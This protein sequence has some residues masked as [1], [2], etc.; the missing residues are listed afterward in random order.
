[1]S[2]M[3]LRKFIM[4]NIVNHIYP[5]G[6]MEY[7]IKLN[8]NLC[9]EERLTILKNICEKNITLMNKIVDI[10]GLSAQNNSPYIFPKQ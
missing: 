10:R 5:F 2:L 4:F 1:M 8:Y 7:Y 9:M 6:E 3:D